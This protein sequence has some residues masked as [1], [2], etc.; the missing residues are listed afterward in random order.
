MPDFGR[1]LIYADTK[2]FR[3]PRF[4]VRFLADLVVTSSK[5]KLESL[6]QRNGTVTAILSERVRPFS[7]TDNFGLTSITDC[8]VC[9]AVHS[10]QLHVKCTLAGY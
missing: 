1:F 6:M 4:Q 3:R 2:K 5:H 9:G 7:C 8:N 10:M